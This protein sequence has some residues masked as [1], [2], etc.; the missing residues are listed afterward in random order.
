MTL[1]RFLSSREITRAAFARRI[2][3]S[4]V[5]LQRYLAGD[6]FPRPDVLRRIASVTLGEVTANDFVSQKVER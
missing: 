4:R 1:A 6:R 5:T 2:G 3:V